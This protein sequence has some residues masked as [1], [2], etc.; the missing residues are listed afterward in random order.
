MVTVMGTAS[1]FSVAANAKS[2]DQIV[3]QFEFTTGRNRY[4]LAC[5]ASATGLNTEVRIGG[6]TVVADQAIPWTGTAGTLD[7]SAHIIMNQVLNGG[8]AELFF[9]NTTAGAL[10]VDFWMTFE[11]I[12]R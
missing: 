3:G 7:I 6:V 12:G 11:P 4:I 10:T 9:R 2:V 1:A 8:R 5:L